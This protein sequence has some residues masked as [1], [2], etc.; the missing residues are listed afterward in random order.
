MIKYSALRADYLKKFFLCQITLAEAGYDPKEPPLQRPGWHCL[1]LPRKEGEPRMWHAVPPGT[2]PY[3]TEIHHGSKRN[4]S[5]Y[6]D[7][8]TWWAAC[9]KAHDKV[10]LNKRWARE[11]GYLKA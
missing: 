9:R 5:N 10:E 2:I 3:S 8:S 7:T 6:L 1:P 4:G 11:K